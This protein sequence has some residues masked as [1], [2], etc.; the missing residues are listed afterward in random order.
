MAFTCDVLT[1]SEQL[2]KNAGACL[3]VHIGFSAPCNWAVLYL[4]RFIRVISTYQQRSSS[5]SL[6]RLRQN[7]NSGRKSDHENHGMREASSSSCS[8]VGN[9]V[10]L[11][12]GQ[13]K[14]VYNSCIEYCRSPRFIVIQSFCSPPGLKYTFE[15]AQFHTFTVINGRVAMG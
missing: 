11:R 5:L 4:L 10:A 2:R 6:E 15:R 7:H 14:E 8:I 13:E 9:E 12:R 3:A 1:V